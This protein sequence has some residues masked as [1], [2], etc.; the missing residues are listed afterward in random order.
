MS[1]SVSISDENYL[2]LDSLKQ[3]I[4]DRN[5]FETF[6]DVITRLLKGMKCNE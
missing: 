1:K 2:L 3:K 6:N 4:P 5:E